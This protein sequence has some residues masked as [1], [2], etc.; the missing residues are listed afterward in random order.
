MDLDLDLSDKM[1]LDFWDCLERNKTPSYNRKN[2]VDQ[3]RKHSAVTAV[4]PLYDKTYKDKREK[5]HLIE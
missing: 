3:M 5:R 1:D 2:M 4:C